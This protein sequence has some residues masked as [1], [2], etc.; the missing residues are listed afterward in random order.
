MGIGFTGKLAALDLGD[1]RGKGLG[2]SG[3][4]LVMGALVVLG[5]L[6]R[7]HRDKPDGG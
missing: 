5:Q 2:L 4:R 7:I 1:M 3:L 6:G